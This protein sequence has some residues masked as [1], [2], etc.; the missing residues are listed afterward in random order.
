VTHGAAQAEVPGGGY[1]V[2]HARQGG[3][4]VGVVDG[5]M[6]QGW[7]ERQASWKEGCR[8]KVRERR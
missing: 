2:G 8:R 6:C 7:K 1:E 3:G 4:T 5:R